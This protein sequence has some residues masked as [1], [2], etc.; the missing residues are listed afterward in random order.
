MSGMNH[1]RPLFA[2]QR[3]W[4][5]FDSMESPKARR[6]REARE[7]ISLSKSAR[8]ERRYSKLDP[9]LLS[10][11]GDDERMLSIQVKRQHGEDLS[12]SDQAWSYEVLR[13]QA[14]KS[15]PTHTEQAPRRVQEKQSSR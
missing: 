7:G 12:A 3:V 1:S 10:Y 2:R 4:E 14:M 9:L 15:I 8:P 6:A 13:H 11:G 5:R